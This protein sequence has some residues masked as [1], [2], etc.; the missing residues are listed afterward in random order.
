MP[1]RLVIYVSHPLHLPPSSCVLSSLKILLISLGSDVPPL[2]PTCPISPAKDVQL[3]KHH[4]LTPLVCAT[5]RAPLFNIVLAADGA[6][7]WSMSV[8]GMV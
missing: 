3:T 5:L 4:Q 8:M 6:S 7:V 1:S 2:Q